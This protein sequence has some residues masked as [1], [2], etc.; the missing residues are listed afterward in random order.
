MKN[1]Q[2]L[3]SI[4]F[5][6]FLLPT[7][8]QGTKAYQNYD[9]VAG[10]KIIFEDNFKDDKEGEFASH[11]D[12][13]N[14]QAVLN[15]MDNDL[16][17]K[18]TDG[19]YGTIFPLM[20]EKNYLPKEFTL[21]YDYYQIT[22][23]YGLS[24]WFQNIDNAECVT[25]KA[26]R[27]ESS[28]SYFVDDDQRTLSGNAPEELIGENFENKWHH[29]AFIF[30]NGMMKLYIDQF[31]VLNVPRS[32]SMPTKVFFGGIGNPENPLIFKNVKIAAGGD[33]NTI[34]Q[35]FTDGKYV[36]HGIRFDVNKATIKPESMGEINA[37]AKIL[38]DN[39][40]LKMEVGG[41]T[42]SDGD[43]AANLKLSQARADAVKTQL[44]SS[45]V[46]TNRLTTKGYGETKPIGDNATFEGKANNRRVEFVKI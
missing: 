44:I 17:M 16:A 42:D 14:G 29:M 41:Y 43:D 35:A 19:N 45:G 7:F 25:V 13:T 5:L 10:Q 30:K 40:S 9:F 26:N 2:A 24:V 23:A 6:G 21:E 8:S 39:T 3:T 11:W 22:G 33:M 20:K 31:R 36:S 15:K 46:E 4:L 32:T 1:I 38:K 28:V 37:I 12:I 27:S 18:I 34:G